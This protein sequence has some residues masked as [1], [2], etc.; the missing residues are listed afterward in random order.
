VKIEIGESLMR[1][2]LR[3][4]QRCQLAELNW[5]PS[6]TWDKSGDGQRL[7]DQARVFFQRALE[8]T[9]F[10]E[11][12]KASQL[13][14][15][16]EIDVLGV[17][18]GLGGRV[19]AVYGADVAFHENGLQYKDNVAG[20]L[21]KLVRGRIAIQAYFGEVPCQMVFASPLVR[22][23]PLQALDAALGHVRAFFADQ[24]LQ[25]TT[26]FYANETFRDDILY[27][28]LQASAETA[29]SSELFL[30]SYRLLTGFGI[31]GAHASG[32]VSRPAPANGYA[33]GAN[34]GFGPRQPSGTRAKSDGEPV[35]EDVI[36]RWASD[37]SL[38]VHR[39]LGLAVL[40]D[41]L[42]REQLVGEI[43]RR[44]LSRDAYGA[45]ASL[46]S[47]GGNNYGLVF[48]E[49]QGQFR[50]HPRIDELVRG[51]LWRSE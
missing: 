10:P 50:F 23:G 26:S 43:R 40:L 30:R 8:I 42:S 9:L 17:K 24:R 12:G 49:A 15:Q 16:A 4:V 7:M 51:Q 18:V 2:W 46:M 6:S 14:K 32:D 11:D 13:I 29:D 27:P 28:T 21:K 1:S 3:H 35:S 41:P 47:N 34:R 36:R 33:A 5:K 38:K 22:P 31:A 48:M 39:I 20:I 45:V 37:P 25:T 44:N 19:E